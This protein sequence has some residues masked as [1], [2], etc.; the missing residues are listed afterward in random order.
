MEMMN[1]ATDQNSTSELLNEDQE[2]VE[3]HLLYALINIVTIIMIGGLGNLL[4]ISSICFARTRYSI[5]SV[6]Y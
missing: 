1:E 6:S 3:D 5:S 2:L 4:T